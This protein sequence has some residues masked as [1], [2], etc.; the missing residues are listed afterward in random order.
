[1]LAVSL[2]VSG[3]TTP[4]TTTPTT[5]PVTPTSPTDVTATPAPTPSTATEGS[6]PWIEAFKFDQLNWYTYTKTGGT[7]VKIEYADEAYND[8]PARKITT[9]IDDKK[10]QESYVDK[11][12]G[13]FLA[14][15]SYLI[16]GFDQEMSSSDFD[17]FA[18]DVYFTFNDPE[19]YTQGLK[20][21]SES[22]TTEAGTFQATKYVTDNKYD[23]FWVSDDAPLPVKYYNSVT[24][25]TWEPTAWG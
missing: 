6:N 5:T 3:C 15:T 19:D 7:N 12:S 24:D 13:E 1:M 18:N 4:A 22:V 10:T 2:S 25:F 17:S 11:A 21:S 14:G 8:Q 20:S 23:S 9:Y 16:P